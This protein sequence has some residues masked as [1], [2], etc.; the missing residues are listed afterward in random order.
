MP[1]AYTLLVMVTVVA[2][3]VLEPKTAVSLLALFQTTF[4]TPFH[5]WVLLAGVPQNPAPSCAPGL[6]VVGVPSHV[7]VAAW[8]ES[9]MHEASARPSRRPVTALPTREFPDA[10]DPAC[11]SGRRRAPAE[12]M[13]RTFAVAS[14]PSKGPAGVASASRS[15]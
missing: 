7:I 9:E 11:A 1:P 10:P 14:D 15:G 12:M 13:A 6:A 3:V 2:A 5:Q 8:R 4:A